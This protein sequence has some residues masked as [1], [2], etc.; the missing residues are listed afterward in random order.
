MNE[1]EI[2]RHERSKVVALL[3][4]VATDL[5]KLGNGYDAKFIDEI[6]K[7]LNS[8]DWENDTKNWKQ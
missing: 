2:R 3:T 4:R 6:I 1:Q 5:R 8:P 7:H